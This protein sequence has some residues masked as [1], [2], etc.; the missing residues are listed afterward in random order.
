[1]S[2]FYVPAESL[3]ESRAFRRL[4]VVSLVG[5]ILV[6]LA[7][8]LHN[9][10]RAKLISPS[11]VTVQIVTSLPKASAQPKPAPPKPPAAKPIPK[12]PE[13]APPPPK[14][15]VKEIVIPKEPQPLAKPKPKAEPQPAP[16]KKAE[17]PPPTPEEL[18]AKINEKV[19]AEE[20]ANAAQNP[21]PDAKPAQTVQGGA[22]EFDPLFSPW[23]ARVRSLV[24]SNWTGASMCPGTVSFDVDIDAAG[25]LNHISLAESSGDG[26]CD[27]T[28]ERALRKSNPLPP[29]PHAV[30]LTLTLNPK[31]TD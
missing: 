2:S 26:H 10:G 12:P 14:P 8:T 25:T 24:R 13:P 17:P 7:L 29:P 22:G 31:D 15:V 11:P 23:V 21:P 6:L 28:G 1:M 9:F 4:L 18:M 27:E 30:S 19:E 16:P 5:H 3:L 20:A